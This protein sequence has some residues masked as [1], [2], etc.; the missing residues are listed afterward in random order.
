MTSQIVTRVNYIFQQ[1]QS[2]NNSIALSDTI[3]EALKRLFENT[4]SS[5][6]FPSKV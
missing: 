3:D 1:I 4:L 2:S 6:S 5:F